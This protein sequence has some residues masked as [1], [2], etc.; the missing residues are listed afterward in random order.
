MEVSKVYS[1]IHSYFINHEHKWFNKYIFKRDWESDFFCVSKSGYCIE[2]EVKI[3]KGDFMADFK[4]GKHELFK[5]VLLNKNYHIENCGSG[6]EGSYIGKKENGRS[7]YAE[8][9]RIKIYDL[10]KI[11]IP[12]KFWYAVPEGLI[13]AKDVPKYAGL[14]YVIDRGVDVT[15]IH[16]IVKPAPFIHKRILEKKNLLFDKYFW[17]R[18]SLLR[19]ID[20]L[21]YALSKLKK[22]KGIE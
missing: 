19:E 14:I 9:S 13:E 3:S 2:V 16:K 6:Y 8:C 21:K 18:V 5:S 4:K 10:N 11:P 15:P 20:S 12:N 17:D 1:A 22:I 7:D